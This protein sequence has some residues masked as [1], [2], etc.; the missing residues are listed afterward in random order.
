MKSAWQFRVAHFKLGVR[1]VGVMTSC[2]RLF[3]QA[4]V[5]LPI[6]HCEV[7]NTVAEFFFFSKLK[8]LSYVQPKGHTKG[9]QFKRICVL[10]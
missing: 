2:H 3:Y 8:L 7:K 9:V 6:K 4:R 5:C 1:V 10:E